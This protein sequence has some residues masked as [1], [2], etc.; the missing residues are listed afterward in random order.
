MNQKHQKAKRDTIRKAYR[1]LEQPATVAELCDEYLKHDP[2]DG[3]VWAWLGHSLIDLGRYLGRVFFRLGALGDAEEC[4]NRAVDVKGAHPATA[5]YELGRMLRARSAFFEARRRFKQ[6][7]A[8]DPHED[9][10]LALADV[11]RVIRVQSRRR[12]E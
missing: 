8:V 7:L 5:L 9:V 4:F 10:R 12:S 1:E 11:E 2:L 3:V 6:A